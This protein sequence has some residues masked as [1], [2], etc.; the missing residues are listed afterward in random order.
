MTALCEIRVVVIYDSKAL[1]IAKVHSWNDSVE[2]NDYYRKTCTLLSFLVSIFIASQKLP[3][4]SREG[5]RTF[6]HSRAV[7]NL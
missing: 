6:H 7:A 5:K 4:E 3:G 1:Q 2:P